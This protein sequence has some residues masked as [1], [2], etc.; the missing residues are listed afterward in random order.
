MYN[1]NDTNFYGRFILYTQLADNCSTTKLKY[2]TMLNQLLLIKDGLTNI[3]ILTI[4]GIWI[5]TLT[6]A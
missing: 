4:L 6:I 2:T 3:S 1:Y 5:V